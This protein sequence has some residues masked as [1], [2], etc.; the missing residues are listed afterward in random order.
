MRPPE[1][2]EASPFADDQKTLQ[3]FGRSLTGYLSVWPALE[4]VDVHG[5]KAKG[6]SFEK[7]GR[8]TKVFN[9]GTQVA[10]IS[11]VPSK[12]KLMKALR[13]NAKDS[14]IRILEAAM[15][16]F[17]ASLKLPGECRLDCDIRSAGNF[18]EMI[19]DAD[20]GIHIMS[21]PPGLTGEI[22][23]HFR[24]GHPRA[25]LW[26]KDYRD[27]SDV[28][29]KGAEDAGRHPRAESLLELFATISTTINE[30]LER[31]GLSVTKEL[32]SDSPQAATNMTVYSLSYVNECGSDIEYEFEADSVAEAKGV[33]TE[34]V[35]GREGLYSAIS[36]SSSDDGY[37]EFD[38]AGCEWT[39]GHEPPSLD[40][41]GGPN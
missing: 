39:G 37:W 34:R 33:A 29:H 12:P 25:T 21:T 11:G 20:H 13:Q 6:L 28:L 18:A 8:F 40:P 41:P 19:G 24:T 14:T 26:L 32:K 38:Y 7:D 1:P 23:L 4:D 30:A 36:L 27:D 16:H 17:G 35:A 22:R 2:L 15:E 5:M 10:S 3:V 31:N 9:Y